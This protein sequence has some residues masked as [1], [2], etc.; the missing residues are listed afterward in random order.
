LNGLPLLDEFFPSDPRFSSPHAQVGPEVQPNLRLR[1]QFFRLTLISYTS[2]CFP[3]PLHYDRSP[4]AFA[5]PAFWYILNPHPE[6]S[7]SSFF[8]SCSVADYN[9]GQYS[10]FSF[11]SLLCA[12]HVRFLSRGPC[13]G[14]KT[15]PHVFSCVF[16]FRMLDE[17]PWQ[18]TQFNLPPDVEDLPDSDIGV[19]P[20]L[21]A[22]FS[23]VFFFFSSISGLP[24]GRAA[25]SAPPTPERVWFYLFF[26]FPLPFVSQSGRRVWAWDG[27]RVREDLGRWG[28]FPFALP[29]HS[30]PPANDALGRAV[31]LRRDF[32]SASSFWQAVSGA[33]DNVW[34]GGSLE[35]PLHDSLPYRN[36][37]LPA[38]GSRGGP[39]VLDLF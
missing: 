4:L 9:L 37:F 16:F 36:H 7:V 6:R 14:L 12:E 33:S 32:P 25:S 31:G 24:A 27:W 20:F 26:V 34:P 29:L 10:I 22:P 19:M 35:K 13:C 39:E 21:L 30:H 3:P 28:R 5:R 11:I 18:D 17:C 23:L 38:P 15:F 1:L 8:Y 2:P